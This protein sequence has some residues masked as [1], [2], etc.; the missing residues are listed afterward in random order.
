[1]AII[2]WACSATLTYTIF[3]SLKNV[4]LAL[5]YIFFSPGFS[6]K[7]LEDVLGGGDYK[8]DKGRGR[9]INLSKYLI[10]IYNVIA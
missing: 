9:D 8:P 2:V 7:D 1:M 4:F 5:K 6:D 10:L 3:L